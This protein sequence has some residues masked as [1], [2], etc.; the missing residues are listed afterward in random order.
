[1]RRK[2]HRARRVRA[3]SGTGRKVE[4]PLDCSSKALRSYRKGTEDALGHRLA[5]AQDC[6][7]SAANSDG[8]S[9]SWDSNNARVVF[10]A[11]LLIYRLDPPSRLGAPTRPR[12]YQ[13]SV[14]Y[15]G[16][17]RRYVLSTHDRVTHVV[18]ARGAVHRLARSRAAGVGDD[19]ARDAVLAQPRRIAFTS[20]RRGPGRCPNQDRLHLTR[21]IQRQRRLQARFEM[22]ERLALH[23]TRPRDDRHAARR[24]LTRRRR[25]VRAPPAARAT[26]ALAPAMP[27]PAAPATPPA[28]AALPTGRGGHSPWKSEVRRRILRAAT[29]QDG[30]R[31]SARHAV[32]RASRPGGWPNC[33]RRR[34]LRLPGGVA[35]SVVSLR[36]A[37][38]VRCATSIWPCKIAG[39]RAPR[40]RGTSPRTSTATRRPA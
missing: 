37:A 33:V 12:R 18:D 40:P 5:I 39:P 38:N 21:P 9:V 36:L 35:V 7:R 10:S 20:G 26:Q 8:P 6:A 1:M 17:R 3:F 31:V 32:A 22:H 27:A 2:G 15:R 14:R 30:R 29:R 19:V 24:D 25:T 16:A 11:S 28:C 4:P 34:W 23:D 13:P